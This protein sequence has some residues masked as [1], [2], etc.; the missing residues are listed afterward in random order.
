MNGADLR[1]LA[2][3]AAGGG[4]APADA[5]PRC[6][7]GSVRHGAAAPLAASAGAGVLVLALVLGVSALTRSTSRS[8]EPVQTPTTTRRRR[9]SWTTPT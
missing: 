5:S 1:S 4:R 8:Q 6:T 9:R 7:P 2:E 3:R